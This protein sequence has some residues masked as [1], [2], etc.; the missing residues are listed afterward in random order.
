MSK[1][2]VRLMTENNKKTKYQVRYE[3]ANVTDGKVTIM[4]RKYNLK[5]KYSKRRILDN[6]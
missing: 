4:S 3:L 2:L 1:K 5:L 6:Q